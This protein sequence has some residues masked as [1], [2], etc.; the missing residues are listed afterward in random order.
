MDIRNVDMAPF[1]ELYESKK[2]R[3]IEA[4]FDLQKAL[5]DRY[6]KVE[7]LPHYPVDIHAP[8]NQI[9]IKDFIARIT[10]E[11]GEAY[12]SYDW[13]YR[14]VKFNNCKGDELGA[15]E[16]RIHN[17][18]EEIADAIHFIIEAF[19]FTGI[20]PHTVNAFV[21]QYNFPEYV[22]DDL[23]D[24]FNLVRGST[25]EVQGYDHDFP[26]IALS[27]LQNNL[28][29]RGGQMISPF[30]RNNIAI[31]MWHVTY[32]LQLARNALKNKPWKQSHMMSDNKTFRNNM[33]YAFME[34]VD[35]CDYVDIHEQEFLA[36]Y[37]AKNQV[38][39]FRI[40][41]KY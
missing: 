20:T 40:T 29:T 25:I 27:H 13:L 15:A 21:N 5:L 9:M 16:Q 33:I 24:T 12:E 1:A 14:W 19:I 22:P 30:T 39:H 10:E 37:W 32:Y 38:N 41:S 11:L 6:I 8:T 18:N 26:D 28:L 2:N 23:G 35:F 3:I 31:K 7:K 34:L 17:F 36:I 4:I